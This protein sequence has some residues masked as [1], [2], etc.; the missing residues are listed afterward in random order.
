MANVAAETTV[1][2]V[3]AGII[4]E[5]NQKAVI[6]KIITAKKMAVNVTIFFCIGNGRSGVIFTGT[7]SAGSFAVVFSSNATKS[8]AEYSSNNLSAVCRYLSRP[9]SASFVSMAVCL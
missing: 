3:T 5:T 4:V 1:I 8:C 6:A 2:V 7:A 9:F